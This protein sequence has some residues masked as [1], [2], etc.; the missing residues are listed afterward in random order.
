MLGGFHNPPSQ[1]GLPYTGTFV[2]ENGLYC[3]SRK[4]FWESWLLKQLRQVIKMMAIV[5]DKPDHSYNPEHKP[6]PWK[7]G[8]RLHAGDSGSADSDYDIKITELPMGIVTGSSDWY[9]LGPEKNAETTV[10]GG[11][12]Q[13]IAKETGRSCVLLELEQ[14]T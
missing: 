11:G 4:I 12:D 9:C 3:M 7:T 10:F 2:E 8:V 5:P 1:I 13:G 14:Y 6:Y